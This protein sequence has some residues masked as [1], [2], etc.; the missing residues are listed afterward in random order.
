MKK[1]SNLGFEVDDE[2]DIISKDGVEL[3]VCECVEKG[4]DDAIT[5][6]KDIVK[7][8]RRKP[9]HLVTNL[10]EGKIDIVCEENGEVKSCWSYAFGEGVSYK[11]SYRKASVRLRIMNRD[12][13]AR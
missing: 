5:L 3:I 9:Y 7:D 11:N 13:K 4:F 2:K 12:Y 1:K 8:H 10:E 6:F